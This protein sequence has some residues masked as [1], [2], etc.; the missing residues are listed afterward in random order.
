MKIIIIRGHNKNEQKNILYE[1]NRKN[2]K[3][4]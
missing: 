1:K 2:I 3:N 4:S